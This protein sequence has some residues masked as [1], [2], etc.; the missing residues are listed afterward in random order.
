MTAIICAI[1]I[2]LTPAPADCQRGGHAV[3]E[4]W[5]ERGGHAALVL[6]PTGPVPIWACIHGH[7][8][9]WD[10]DG[11][12]F[13]G[14]LQMDWGFMHAYGLDKIKAYGGRLANAWSPRDQ[15]VVAWRAVVGYGRFGPRGYGPWPNTRR[16]CA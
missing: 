8:A 3:H 1:A 5:M 10:D 7:E 4:P 14:G 15:M 11:A 12:P 6:E 2:T 9:A 16:G 13:W